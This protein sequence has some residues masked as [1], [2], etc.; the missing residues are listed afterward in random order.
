M[1]R[2]EVWAARGM[3]DLPRP[4]RRN[5]KAEEG[6]KKPK[7][8]IP[9]MVEVTIEQDGNGFFGTV[10]NCVFRLSAYAPAVSTGE[11]WQCMFDESPS[12]GR[13]LLPMKMIGHVTVEE[14]VEPEVDEYMAEEESEVFEEPPVQEAPVQV[15]DDATIADLMEQIRQLKETNRTLKSKADRVDRMERKCKDVEDENKKLKRAVE[16]LKTQ[17]KVLNEKDSVKNTMAV[18]SR[19]KGLE[20]DMESKDYEISKLREKLKTLGVDDL[21]VVPHMPKVP[22]AFLTGEDTIHCTF[23]EDGRYS[24]YVSPRLK[25]IRIVPDDKGRVWCRDRTLH[26]GC[27]ASFSGFEKARALSFEN[28]DD[29]VEIRL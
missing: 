4:K 22:K 27:I 18:E 21:S 23:L 14:I 7:L 13:L 16:S 9:D 6:E 28:I 11:I 17:V 20:D 8:P 25:A 24:V 2:K 29:G 3:S 10:D 12:Y 19:I 15:T 1:S 5:K 26:L